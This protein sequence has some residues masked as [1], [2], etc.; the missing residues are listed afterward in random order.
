MAD[1]VGAR[2]GSASLPLPA[3]KTAANREFLRRETALDPRR[4]F[5]YSPA[6]RSG[7]R[8]T[9][10][11]PTSAAISNG[12][13]RGRVCIGGCVAARLRNSADHEAA[14]SAWRPT[15]PFASRSIRDRG[16]FTRSRKE[17][18]PSPPWDPSFRELFH[19]PRRRARD[20]VSCS[21]AVAA[22]PTYGLAV[23]F[24]TARVSER[25]KSKRSQGPLQVVVGIGCV[26]LFNKATTS[27]SLRGST[28]R[29][30]YRRANQS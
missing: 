27:A 26:R 22:P 14:Q 13:P 5:S 9:Q 25:S 23:D 29:F 8:S 19:A 2:R 1:R 21:P 17:R 4:P 6:S 18:S 16:A 28:C 11:G 20:R 12:Y 24:T 30:T 7:R 15:E 3:A 10:V